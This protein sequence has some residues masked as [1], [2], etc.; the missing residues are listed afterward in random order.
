[1]AMTVPTTRQLGERQPWVGCASSFLPGSECWNN[2]SQGWGE[3]H[4]SARPV[5]LL[6]CQQGTSLNLSKLPIN[7]L[8]AQFTLGSPQNG[9]TI[10]LGLSDI[11]FFRIST[12]AAFKG[13][14]IGTT[15]W[16]ASQKR[17]T[18]SSFYYFCDSFVSWEQLLLPFRS[19]NTLWEEHWQFPSPA[20]GSDRGCNASEHKEEQCLNCTGTCRMLMHNIDE[21]LSSKFFRLPEDLSYM[22]PLLVTS[23]ASQEVRDITDNWANS[24]RWNPVSP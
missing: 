7:L 8:G 6:L 14:K 11:F 15:L 4:F 1:M 16:S 23:P 5:L 9:L 2:F 19:T 24:Q 22:I 12:F 18:S 13:R 21:V 17:V 3:A 10:S 20:L